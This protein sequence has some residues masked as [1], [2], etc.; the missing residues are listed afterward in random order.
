V[1]ETSVQAKVEEH[2]EAARAKA[3]RAALI[4]TGAVV[5][6][7]LVLVVVVNVFTS[8][9][10]L[11][12]GNLTNVLRQITY[13]AILAVGQTFVIIT[14]GIDLSVGSLIELTG[15]VMATFANAMPWGSLSAARPG[16]SMRFRSY[17]ST[18]RRSS[19]R[20]R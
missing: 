2:A 14:A 13:N 11:T 20:L 5:V 7:L 9:H 4:R 12:A 6:G 10:F 1:P 19:R 18:C 15:V 17:A 3:G 8:G 16:S